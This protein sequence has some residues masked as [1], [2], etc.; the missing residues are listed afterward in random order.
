MKK[1]A[2]VRAHEHGFFLFLHLTLFPSIYCSRIIAL[3]SGST[4]DI[5]TI[6]WSTPIMGVVEGTPVISSD[7]ERIYV[8]S[9]TALHGI[10]T[11]LD[12]SSGSLVSQ[13]IDPKP[14]THYGPLSMVT[15]NG[16]D[17]LFWVDATDRGYATRGRVHVVVSDFLS[18]VHSQRSF[19]SSSTVAPT[20][21]SDGKRIW[22]GG[23]SAT[24]HGWD[25]SSLKPIW[26][27]QLN[28]S[29]RNESYR[30]YRRD[31]RNKPDFY[32][33]S[34]LTMTLHSFSQQLSSIRSRLTMANRAFLSLRRAIR[35]IALMPRMVM[36]FGRQTVLRAFL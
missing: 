11:V 35:C 4:N 16:I 30:K 7:G 12:G 14:M 36:F 5:G 3:N 13:T 15:N 20:L 33:T 2:F 22:I 10:L 21:S 23:R 19:E 17:K 29:N 9:N 32:I 26:S 25:D 8:T 28:P 24:V 18:A 6:R 1:V 27:T 34:K 31:R